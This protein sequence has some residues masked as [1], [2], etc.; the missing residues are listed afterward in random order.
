MEKKKLVN[1]ADVLATNK[2]AK[3]TSV[4]KVRTALLALAANKEKDDRF[5][6]FLINVLRASKKQPV[7]Y[8]SFV[9]NLAP[10]KKGLYS[11]FYLLGLIKRNASLYSQVIAKDI[12][13]DA[14]TA[15]INKA[16]QDR[17]AEQARKAA[18]KAAKE[19]AKGA[20]TAQKATKVAKKAA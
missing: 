20:N 19:A 9:D 14:F 10:N 12:P 16:E 6:T 1:Q 4:N 13:D 15:S 18:N 2:A 8:R 7:I 3:Y 11:T 17:K 5:N